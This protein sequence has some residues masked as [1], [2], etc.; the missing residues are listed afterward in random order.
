MTTLNELR[1]G[2]AKELG[3]KGRWKMN[4][5]QLEEAI[6]RAQD[7]KKVIEKPIPK[8]RTILPKGVKPKPKSRNIIHE[9]V[10]PIP[11]PRKEESWLDWFVKSLRRAGEGLI[12]FIPE[13]KVRDSAKK[14]LNHIKR[15]EEAISK[16]KSK[17]QEK[18]PEPE[19]KE[20][21]RGKIKNIRIRGQQ[22][23]DIPTFFNRNKKRIL[24]K[25]REI[26]KPF[27]IRFVLSCDY[28]MFKDQKFLEESIY[29]HR[30]QIEEIYE[31]TDIEEF[32]KTMSQFLLEE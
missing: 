8:P 16:P 14:L 6:L 29:H 30:S 25:I 5:P 3:I 26:P 9:G 2:I 1:K 4:K 28:K 7:E 15:N 31:S 17:E 24:E 12:N 21:P 23:M 27:K 22:Q 32:Y 20:Y 10:K 13:G 11:T 19:V 18:Q